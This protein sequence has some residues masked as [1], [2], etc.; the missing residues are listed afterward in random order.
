MSWS[1]AA[2]GLTFLQH[3]H[4]T[5]QSTMGI[6]SSPSTAVS[7]RSALLGIFLGGFVSWGGLVWETA[8]SRGR[9]VTGAGVV[10]F[11]VDTVGDG[12]RS[13][14]RLVVVVGGRFCRRRL[15]CDHGQHTDSMNCRWQESNWS[16]CS[17]LPST[18]L[19]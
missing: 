16:I 14:G 12:G 11:A 13:L 18:H 7:S 1:L 6:S 3:N 2:E 15:S 9:G 10:V 8:M 19:C 4:Q 5:H 17:W